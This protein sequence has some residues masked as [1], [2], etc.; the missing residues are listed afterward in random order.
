M[1]GALDNLLVDVRVRE[2]NPVSLTWLSDERPKPKNQ[3]DDECAN[4]CYDPSGGAW[5]GFIKSSKV[6]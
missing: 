3:A 1:K 2:G 5:F 6:R 4:E